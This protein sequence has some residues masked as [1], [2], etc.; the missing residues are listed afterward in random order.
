MVVRLADT[1]EDLLIDI[2]DDSYRL[3][4]PASLVRLLDQGGD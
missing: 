3:A 4:A 1:D 2:L